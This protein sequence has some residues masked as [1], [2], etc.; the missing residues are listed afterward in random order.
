[1]TGFSFRQIKWKRKQNQDKLLPIRW[2]FSTSTISCSSVSGWSFNRLC[3]PC[4]RRGLADGLL[5]SGSPKADGG[6]V[7]VRGRGG[8][9]RRRHKSIVLNI[10]SWLRQNFDAEKKQNK[11]TVIKG[12]KTTVHVSVSLL[13]YMHCS[14]DPVYYSAAVSPVVGT[15]SGPED[16]NGKQ[17]LREHTLT[18]WASRSPEPD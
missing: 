11:Q 6:T 16:T 3:R 18:S 1:M 13:S 17:L 8:R 4:D 12:N 2:K 10:F 9:S 14:A 15:G 5:A 7:R